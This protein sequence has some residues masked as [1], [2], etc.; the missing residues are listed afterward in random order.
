MVWPVILNSHAKVLNQLKIFLFSEKFLTSV[1]K[2]QKDFTRN[3]ILP[4]PALILFL[5]NFLKGSLQDELDYFFKHISQS[6]LPDRVVSKS[7]LCQARKKLKPDTFRL[8]NQ[9]FIQAAYKHQSNLKHWKK[10]RL[11]AADGTSILVPDTKEIIE[12][13]G[14]AK[15]Y[16]GTITPMTQVLGLYDPL[17]GYMV[18]ADIG[19]YKSD[20]R[21][22]LYGLLK[23][24]S[25]NDL[26]I[27][28]RGFPAF[29][30]FSAIL[31]HNINLLCR[32]PIGK[33]KVA[34]NLIDSTKNEQIITLEANSKSKRTCKKYG[35]PTASFKLRL[36]KVMLP[37]QKPEVLITSL[38]DDE[39]YPHECFQE[40]YFKRWSIEED[41]KLLKSRLKVSH[42]TGVTPLTIYQDLFAKLFA[43]NVAAML[44]SVPDQKLQNKEQGKHP[45]QTNRTQVISKLKDI[46]VSLFL[47][48][49][50]ELKKTIAK[51]YN[52]FE[53]TAEPIRKNRKQKYPRKRK[54]KSGFAVQYK[55]T[56]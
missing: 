51:L 13:F 50:R 5:I 26:L 10:H 1:R 35:L 9:A 15:N 40:L 46:I 6:D 48:P 14:N 49:C 56:R 23:S 2:E 21:K 8:L 34:Q 17:N 3:R 25:S 31:N 18:E 42:F 33:W 4:F 12:H 22:Q 16:V 45:C 28:D 55:P 19:P 47:M 54:K 38:L 11:I 20:E 36:I 44:R 41:F 53:K 52:L 30:L 29:W 32:L 43:K 24:L 37:N 7:A 39:K 27:L